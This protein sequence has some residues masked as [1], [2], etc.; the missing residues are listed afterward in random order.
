M[1]TNTMKTLS[2]CAIIAA[3]TS[4]AHADLTFAAP[5][6]SAPYINTQ[7]SK[8]W[9]SNLGSYWKYTITGYEYRLE[10]GVPDGGKIAGG[11]LRYKTGK[12]QFPGAT[13][14]SASINGQTIISANLSA[15]YQSDTSGLVTHTFSTPIVIESQNITPSFTYTTNMVGAADHL[16]IRGTVLDDS[17]VPIGT[18]VAP[19]FV[20]DGGRPTLIWAI[21]RSLGDEV[22]NVSIPP[23]TELQAPNEGSGKS[24]NGHGNNVDGIDSSNPGKSA[25]K[26][27]S[28]GYYDTDY[29]GDGIAED[30]EGHGGGSAMS[31]DPV[32]NP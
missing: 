6:M 23:E 1:K 13:S 17:P 18:L 27:A 14:L 28:K 7:L 15:S 9:S 12:S 11:Q 20:R 29:D 31:Q 5:A 24:N 21:S 8:T 32:T 26:W 4:I 25:A 16:I 3:G 10:A 2:A 30:D 22:V 19:S